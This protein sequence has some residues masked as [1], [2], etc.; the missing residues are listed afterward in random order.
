MQQG[1]TPSHARPLGIAAATDSGSDR[2][3]RKPNGLDR[4]VAS[5]LARRMDPGRVRVALWDE[6]AVADEN[7]AAVLWIGDPGALWKLAANPGLQFGDLYSSGRIKVQGD[8]MAVVEQGY[9][10]IGTASRGER[11]RR[12]ASRLPAP[13]LA[14]SRRNIHHHYDLGNDFYRL[15]LDREALQYTCA[16][17]ADP[18]MTLEQAQQ[19]KMHHVCRKLRLRRGDRVVEAGSGWGGFALFMAKHYGVQVRS[20]NIAREQ[21]QYAR[22][23][24]KREN[25]G[26]QVEFVADDFRNITGEYDVFVSIG[27]LEHVGPANYAGL[28]RLMNRVLTRE[29]RGLVHTIGRDAPRPLNAWINRRIFPGA[30]PPTLRQMMDLFEP[31]GLSV[32]D[33]ENIRLHYAKT[34]QDWLDRYEQNVDQVHAMFD[35]NFVRAWRLYLTGSIAGF[36]HGGLQL[37]QVH[38]ARSGVNEIP[39]TRADIY[40]R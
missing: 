27:M 33:V 20:F 5:Q 1:P 37:F 31:N 28:G 2:R 15:W 21:V 38:F 25:L 36:V 23:W 29:G 22:D 34:L 30:Y 13:D 9:R 6:S 11:L 26:D 12:L 14:D 24:V 39:W 18:S 4:W 32:L 16:Y 7:P 40:P 17:Y 19:A 10:N 8:L 35:E 3:Q